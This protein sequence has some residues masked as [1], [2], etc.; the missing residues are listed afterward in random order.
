MRMQDV[1]YIGEPLARSSSPSVL[2]SSSS[3]IPGEDSH[4]FE[5]IA[6]HDK[7]RGQ[8]S[9]FVDYLDS[10]PSFPGSAGQGRQAVV[11]MNSMYL[12]TD[13]PYWL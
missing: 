13:S 10:P 1:D 2:I 3:V 4:G 9:G 12:I 11:S 5:C 6:R 7:R 8:I